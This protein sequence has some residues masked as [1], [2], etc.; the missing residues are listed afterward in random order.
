MS[1][2]TADITAEQ[3]FR[4]AFERLK[5]N[6]PETL[7]PG[8]PVSQ[9]NVAKEAK[10]DPSALRKSRFPSL[11]RE[12]QA[13]IEIHRQ[14]RPS[15]RQE[16]LKKRAQRADLRKRL[17]A[18]IMERD[19]AQSQ[20]LSAQRRVMELATELRT[21]QEELAALQHVSKLKK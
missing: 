1:S 2:K 14:I 8:T 7:E 9:N 4:Q 20:L 19:A 12:I 18:V 21:T 16:L 13:Y 10:C 6:N 15:Q 5:A 11:I 3:R 17:A